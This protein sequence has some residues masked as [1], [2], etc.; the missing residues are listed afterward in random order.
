GIGNLGSQGYENPYR[1]SRGTGIN[2]EFAAKLRHP[3]AHAKNTNTET[4]AGAVPALHGV[5]G[6]AATAV[7]HIEVD[8]SG[9]AAQANRGRLAAGVALNVC[10]TFLNDAKESSLGFLWEAAKAGLQVQLHFHAAALAEAFGVLFDGGNQAE[11]VQ[12]RR[13]QEIGESA[14]LTRHLL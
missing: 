9:I 3:F 12:K 10:Q 1:R 7:A 13:V 2:L 4:A 6:H 14:N 11:L 8:A 5:L